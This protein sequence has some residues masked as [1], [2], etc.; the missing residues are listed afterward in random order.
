MVR[1]WVKLTQNWT[2]LG[3]LTIGFQ[4]IM[5]WYKK[6]NV[7]DFNIYCPNI[8]RYNLGLPMCM[9]VW[10]RQKL[11]HQIHKNFANYGTFNDQ[12]SEHCG[13]VLKCHVKDVI[14]YCCNNLRFNRRRFLCMGV[15]FGYKLDKIHRNFSKSGTFNDQLSKHLPKTVENMQ[16]IFTLFDLILYDL[17]YVNLS[18]LV[19]YWRKN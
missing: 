6:Y 4:N 17:F 18:Y 7:K 15:R 12:F 14:I 16:H 1:N 2:I 10:F 8:L 19:K 11:G 5:A 13:L 3:L 9:G